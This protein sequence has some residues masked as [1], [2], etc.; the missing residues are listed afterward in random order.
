MFESILPKNLRRWS[1]IGLALAVLVALPGMAQ[2]QTGSI[3]YGETVT[4]SL[5]AGTPFIIYRFA[6]ESSDEISAFAVGVTPG[7]APMLVLLG[8][9]Q[10]Q[11]TLSDGNLFDTQ[12]EAVSIISHR[13]VQSGDYALMVSSR[14]GTPGDFMLHLGRQVS[15]PALTG[16]LQ[17][18]IPAT[19]NVNPTD[20]PTTFTFA[21]D[22]AADSTLV[23]LSDTPQLNFYADVYDGFGQ[24]IARLGGPAVDSAS[25]VL[26]PGSGVYAVSIRAMQPEMSGSVQLLLAAGGAAPPT[27]AP[28][29][30]ATPSTCQVSSNVN[31]NVRRGPGTNY[32]AFGRLFEGTTLEVIGR[33]ST[34][35]WYVVNYSGQEGWV[36]GSV[37]QLAGPCGNLPYFVPP[38]SPTPVIPTATP[39]PQPPFISFTANG[40]NIANIT[41]GNCVTIEWNTA[42]VREVYYEGAGTTGVGSRSECPAATRAYTLRV[43]LVDGTEV[44][45]TV[46]VNVSP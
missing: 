18:G 7:M 25:L 1:I 16:P 33:N 3:A 41:A 40:T 29:V 4:G 35:T 9:D 28:I 37:T 15:Q 21:V 46:A 5:T 11:L 22:Q 27:A 10:R 14:N 39:T 38:P 26:K 34:S 31:V 30:T 6:G 20:L 23:V 42:N 32:D 45:R 36:A 24:M 2:A 43:I 13:L 17:N 12:D 8:P 44:L 19:L